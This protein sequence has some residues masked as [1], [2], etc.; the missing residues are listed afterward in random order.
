M[1][2][3]NSIQYYL[4]QYSLILQSSFILKNKSNFFIVYNFDIHESTYGKEPIRSTDSSVI[5][6]SGS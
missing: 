4:I 6:V 3:S 5:T 1:A 2:L